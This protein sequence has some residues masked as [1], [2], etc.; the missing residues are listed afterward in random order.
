MKK[1]ILNDF[2]KTIQGL[3]K[4]LNEIKN[5]CGDNT[6]WFIRSYAE[7]Y[8]IAESMRN[9]LTVMVETIEA[10]EVTDINKY[11]NDIR[12]EYINNMLAQPLMESS[13]S[14]M[15]RATSLWEN[16]VH[17]KMIKLIDAFYL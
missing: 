1:I 2:N 15:Y 9:K 10:K 17:R 4:R 3:N 5:I 6:L 16:E 14:T 11:L 8:W 7:E 13:S 12:D